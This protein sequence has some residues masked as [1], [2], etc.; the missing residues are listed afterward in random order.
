MQFLR[1]NSKEE[2]VKKAFAA[3]AVF[4]L[5]TIAAGFYLRI[6]SDKIN[7]VPD[8]SIDKVETVVQNI[9]EEKLEVTFSEDVETDYQIGFKEGFSAFINQTQTYIPSP[10]GAVVSYS[11]Y[12]VEDE[13]SQEQ[14]TRGYIDGYHR[15]TSL[16]HCPR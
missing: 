9:E 4:I 7:L 5:C 3:I 2:K 13:E 1:P 16:V 15:A 12:K 8:V 6:K 11:S 10:S 14:K